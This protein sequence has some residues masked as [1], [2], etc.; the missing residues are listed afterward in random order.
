MSLAAPLP[1]RDPMTTRV[2]LVALSWLNWFTSLQQDV[3]AAAARLKTVS[4]TAQAASLA[5]T[6]IPVGVLKSGLY[7]VG[8]MARIT[9]AAST[10]SSLT[11]AIGFTTGG[12]SCS[13]SGV[14]LTGNTTSTVQSGTYLVLVD[15]ASPVTYTTTYASVGATAMAYSLSVVL[16]KVDA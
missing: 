13:L 16:E 3:Q 10:S 6:P 11:V 15:G 8:Y 12:V 2:G 4:L 5:A 14:A 1:A 7:R 9:T